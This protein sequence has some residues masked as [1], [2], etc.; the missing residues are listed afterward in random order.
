MGSGEVSAIFVL[1]VWRLAAATA[2]RELEP[3]PLNLLSQ[4]I[5]SAPLFA[6]GDHGFRVKCPADPYQVYYDN[7]H[8]YW[9]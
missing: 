7:C 2:S 1:T 5:V 3:H 6:L 4:Q 8:F 9:A